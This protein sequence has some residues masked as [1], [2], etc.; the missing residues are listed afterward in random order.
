[1][2]LP[3]A[4]RVLTHKEGLRF[5]IEKSQWFFNQQ[6]AEAARE[7]LQ[8]RE[9]DHQTFSIEVS[10]VAKFRVRWSN[11]QQHTSQEQEFL[12]PVKDSTNALFA[13]VALFL[14]HNNFKIHSSFRV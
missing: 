3:T 7:A 14:G 6:D 4:Y 2:P 9:S 1:M 12:I 8:Q 5:P 13:S 11:R 10:E